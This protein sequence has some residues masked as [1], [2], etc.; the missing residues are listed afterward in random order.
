MYPFKYIYN[1]WLEHPKFFFKDN[2]GSVSC[3]AQVYNILQ[4]YHEGRSQGE[5]VLGGLNPPP[6]M[7][8]W[9]IKM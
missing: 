9:L 4:N 1:F 8:V 2:N 6:E 3:G 7:F 5:E